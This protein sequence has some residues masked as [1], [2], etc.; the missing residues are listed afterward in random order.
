MLAE[1]NGVR[2]NYRQEGAGPADLVLLPGLGATVAA[3][4]AQVRGLS[5]VMRVTAVDPRGHGRSS[6][7]VRPFTIPDL[8]E[9]IAALAR[10]L[11]LGPA[12]V[13]GSSMSTLTC[14]ALAAAHPEQVAGLVLVGGFPTLS[15]QGKERMRQRI[16]VIEAQGMEAQALEALAPAVAA[17]ALGPTTH[18]T[19]PALVGLFQ[20]MIASASP[21][22]Y[23]ESLRALVAADT[24]PLLPRVQ[25]PT[26]VLL[27]AEEQVAPLDQARALKAGIPQAVLRVLPGC[28]HLPFL[29]Q[30]ARFNACVMEFL[31]SLG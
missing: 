22:G 13:V 5:G 10:T 23:A 7:P 19:Q 26:L 31:A 16:G 27:G 11:G 6:E 24:T 29:E 25:C 21:R 4:H 1:V 9:D 15:E 3:W 2:L 8:A 17:T 18:A 28:G 20:Q 12:V 14:V 30:P